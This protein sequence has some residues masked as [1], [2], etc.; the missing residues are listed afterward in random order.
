MKLRKVLSGV[1]ALGMIILCLSS[2]TALATP[3]KL[4]EAYDDFVYM[5][6]KSGAEA[7]ALTPNS[8]SHA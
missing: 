3:A 4:T 7:A 8:S 1:I 2:M 5:P 6:V